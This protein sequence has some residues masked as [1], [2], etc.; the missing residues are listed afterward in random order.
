MSVLAI[1]SEKGGY[2]LRDQGEGWDVTGP[3]FPGWKVTSFTTTPGNAYLAA[4]GSNWFGVSIHRSEDLESW[5]PVASGPEL[6]EGRELE[7]VW[8][9]AA[10]GGRLF[11]GVAQAGLFTS[12]DDG[13]SWQP[14]DALN[15]YPGNESWQPGFGGLAAHHVLTADDRIWVGISAVGV[16]RSDD[17]GE[18]FRRC[19]QGI[20]WVVGE[21]DDDPDQGFCVHGLVADPADPDRIWR[22]DHSGVYRTFDGGDSWER[23]EEGLP[24]RFGF[25]IGRHHA[26]GRLFVVPLQADENRVPVDGRFGVHASDDDGASWHVAGTGWPEGAT[27]TAVLRRSMAID[28]DRVVVGTTGGAVWVSDDAGETWDV[29]PHS[30]PRILSVDLLAERG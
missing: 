18:T 23:I 20:S 6:P 17:G 14:V 12:D 2:L 11:A 15:R 30:F 10:E 27:F 7:Q 16:F 25:P 26:S 22:Q 21:S 1:G 24:S 13:T 8:A 3:V 19:D 9:F 28:G 5:E 4:L 29:L